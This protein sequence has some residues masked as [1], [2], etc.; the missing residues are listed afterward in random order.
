MSYKKES[1]ESLQEQESM[2]HEHINRLRRYREGLEVGILN[3]STTCTQALFEYLRDATNSLPN[4]LEEYDNI[5]I[6]MKLLDIF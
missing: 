4:L 1:L 3:G 6:R 2:L 5:R